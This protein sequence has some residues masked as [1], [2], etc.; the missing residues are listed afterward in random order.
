MG[1]LFTDNAATTLAS[2]INNTDT[3]LTVASSSGSRL[4][5]VTGGGSDFF[6][7]T[8]EDASGNREFIKV[9]HRSGDTLG[10][11]SYPCVRGY[12]GSTARSW[13]TS[14]QVDIRLST[15]AIDDWFE[16]SFDAA[17]PTDFDARMLS[18]AATNRTS[19]GVTTAANPV[20]TGVVTVPAGTKTAPGVR[21]AA[22]STTGFFSDTDNT[23]AVSCNDTEVVRWTAVGLQVTTGQVKFPSTQNPSSDANTL[24]DYKEFDWTPTITYDTPGDLSVTFSTQVGKGVKIGR[25]VV[26]TFDLVASS[27]THTTASGNLYVTGLSGAGITSMNVSG[28]TFSGAGA[29]QGITKSGYTDFA[30][31]MAHNSSSIVI[32]AV[33]SGQLVSNVT[34]ADTPTGGAL[35]LRGTLTLFTA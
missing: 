27:F 12:Y 25:L 14:D 34:A 23:M 4:P 20:F 29:F 7:L 13:T 9:N 21:T 18:N 16:A 30:P 32:G 33:G 31:R 26:V 24:D 10:S 17:F 22:S 1:I 35:I 19:L 15:N 5:S 6:V 28:V 11:V 3:I 2:G 8:M